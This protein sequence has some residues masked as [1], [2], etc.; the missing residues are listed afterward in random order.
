MP[1]SYQLVMLQ[2]LQSK[3]MYLGT[4]SYVEIQRRRAANKIAKQSRKRNRG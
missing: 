4:V 1:N 2:A 3:P